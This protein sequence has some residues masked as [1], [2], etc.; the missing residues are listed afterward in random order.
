MC[1]GKSSNLSSADHHCHLCSLD[2]RSAVG[3]FSAQGHR[4][5]CWKCFEAKAR[6]RALNTRGESADHRKREPPPCWRSVTVTFPRLIHLRICLRHAVAI[7]VLGRVKSGR[8][9][10]PR[11]KKTKKTP[12]TLPFFLLLTE[13]KGW[14]FWLLKGY[15]GAFVAPPYAFP[16]FRHAP[17]QP[18]LGGQKLWRCGVRFF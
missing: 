15:R 13:N 4:R 9:N 10:R 1:E 7:A 17:R 14:L 12:K 6:G 11:C 2:V 8:K 3:P 5:L 16:P 18:G